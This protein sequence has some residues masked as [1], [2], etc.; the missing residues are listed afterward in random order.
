[1][2]NRQNS[3]DLYLAKLEGQ[4]K[5]ILMEKESQLRQHMQQIKIHDIIPNPK[6]MAN[7]GAATP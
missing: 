7:K 6:E 4:Y 5:G 3:Q 2:K 1:M